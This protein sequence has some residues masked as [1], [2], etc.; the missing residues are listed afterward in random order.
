[1]FIDIP[2]ELEVLDAF[3]SRQASWIVTDLA[4]ISAHTTLLESDDIEARLFHPQGPGSAEQV[5]CRMTINELNSLIETAMQDALVRVSGDNFFTTETKVGSEVKLVYR[6]NRSEL[7]QKL[8]QSGILLEP[9]EN[10]AAVLQIKEI[11]EGNKHR[12][13]LRPVPKWDRARKTLVKPATLVPGST[14]T[15]YSSY[16]LELGQVQEYIFKCRNFIRWLSNANP[17]NFI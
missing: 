6:L 14:D 9:S 15:W 8:T 3:F 10:Y 5:L 2:H 4:K 1:M 11:S 17:E 7:E 13:R 12:E 16:E